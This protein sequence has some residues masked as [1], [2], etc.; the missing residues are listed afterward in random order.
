[1]LN[2]DEP[3]FKRY[4]HNPILTTDK[5]PYR[6][7]TVF[8]AGATRLRDGRT[9]LLCRVEDMKGHS[10]LTKAISNDGIT[11]WE[12]DDRPTIDTDL[13]NFPEEL[14]GVEDPRVVYIPE[15]DKYAITYTAYSHA[16]PAVSLALTK[17][18]E[19]FE[20]CGVIMPPEDKNAALFPHKIGDQWALIHRPAGHQGSHIWISYSHD[21]Q[22]WAHH[23]ILLEARRGGW[24]DAYK[25]GL[26]PPLIETSEG[27]LMIYHGVRMTG[28]GCLY[29]LG[30]ALFDLKN[31]EVC[32]LRGND[33]VFGPETH[34]E[35]NGDVPNVVFS[36]GATIADDGD[37]INLY[38]GAADQCIGLAFGSIKRTLAWLKE[39]GRP[40]HETIEH[41]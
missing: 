23:K 30:L 37:T 20:R 24:W 14:W 10:H 1:M 21:L 32:L 15:L 41:Y 12:I 13:S 7:N 31:P 9:V 18:F 11:N 26:G 39:N 34:Y 17:D 19:S 2:L 8:N 40:Y 36:C 29:R 33:W 35:R 6:A 4:E 5:W 38:Y 16:G 22:Y 3:L 28:G 25:I 27:W